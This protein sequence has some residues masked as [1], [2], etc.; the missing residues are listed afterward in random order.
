[1]GAHGHG[2]FGDILYG[3][4]IDPLRHAVRIPILIVREDGRA[5]SPPTTPPA[6]PA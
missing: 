6:T 5:E 2:I 1:M 4:T 3:S